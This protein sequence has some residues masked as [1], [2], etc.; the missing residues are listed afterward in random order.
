MYV[1]DLYNYRPGLWI[2]ISFPL[3]NLLKDN[4]NHSKISKRIINITKSKFNNVFK[5]QLASREGNPFPSYLLPA[6]STKK[7]D[8]ECNVNVKFV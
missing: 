5:N 6:I 3:A 8:H 4:K 1:L 2:H 7:G